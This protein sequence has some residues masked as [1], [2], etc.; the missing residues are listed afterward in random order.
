MRRRLPPLNPLRAFEAAARNLSFTLAADELSV[1]QGAISRQVKTLED[2][3]QTPLFR[4]GFRSLELTGTAKRYVPAI[5]EALNTI[6]YATGQLFKKTGNDRLYVKTSLQTFAMTWLVP[7]FSSFRQLHQDLDVDFVTSISLGEEDFFREPID[8]AVGRER[9]KVKGL[10]AE[11]FM[12]EELLVVCSPNLLSSDNPLSIP[13]DLAHH[14][15]LHNGTRVSCWSVWLR[16]TGTK[17]IDTSSGLVFDSFY[18]T[19]QAAIAGIGVAVLPVP[20]AD[21]SLRQGY[22]VTPFDLP[23]M[24]GEKYYLLYLEHRS[25]VP[26]IRAFRD[27]LFQEAVNANKS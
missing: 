17:G 3:L 9:P 10:K 6:D 26:K 8:V 23:V 24:S 5:Q 16:Q 27:W 15:L 7:R 1:T 2:Y 22:L 4:R 13:A 21:V 20:I 25:E 18:L 11:E 12:E 14:T 19:V